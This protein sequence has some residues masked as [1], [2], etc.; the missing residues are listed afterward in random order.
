MWVVLLISQPNVVEIESPPSSE[1][2]THPPPE[3]LSA[4]PP[5]P[6]TAVFTRSYKNRYRLILAEFKVT[7]ISSE[8]L[9]YAG[10]YSN[11]NWNRYYSIRRGSELEES[12]RTCGT[13]MV[14]QTLLPGKTVTFEVV[15]GEEPDRVQVG[16]DFFVGKERLE[17]TI[18]SDEVNASE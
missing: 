16:F 4:A 18:W 9:Y 7:N 14:E 12:D 1:T 5:K 11:R 10:A 6:A 13:G 3:T 17:Q 8:P 2:I 15:V